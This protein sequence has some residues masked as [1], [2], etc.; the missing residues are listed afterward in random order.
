MNTDRIDRAYT[1]PCLVC[2]NVFSNCGYPLQAALE[3]LPG[4]FNRTKTPWSSALAEASA[5]PN[6]RAAYNSYIWAATSVA[7]VICNT[8]GAHG[9]GSGACNAHAERT[10]SIAATAALLL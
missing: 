2:L 10:R 1:A 6:V 3:D 9:F 4:M 5:L 8:F 7:Q